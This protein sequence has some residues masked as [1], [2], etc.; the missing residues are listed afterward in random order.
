ML[1][2]YTKRDPFLDLSKKRPDLNR[3]LVLF[4]NNKNLSRPESAA[5]KAIYFR[6][7]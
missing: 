7:A 4:P 3:N 6:I 5:L 2:F 1:S